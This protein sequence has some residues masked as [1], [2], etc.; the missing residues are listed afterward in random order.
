VTPEQMQG[1]AGFFGKLATYAP[2][3]KGPV[4]VNEAIPVIRGAWEKASIES[5]HGGAFISH[6]GTKQ[7]L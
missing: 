1:L 7:W 2:D 5:G 4:P 3:F 6:L